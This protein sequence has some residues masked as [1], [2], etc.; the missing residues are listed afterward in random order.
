MNENQTAPK[1]LTKR[2]YISYG[3][4]PIGKNLMYGLVYGEYLPNFFRTKL[5]ISNQF[6][7]VMFFLSKIWDGVNDLLMG[8]IIDRTNSRF[9]KFRPWIFWG[10][11]TNAIV[12][13]MM[14][15]NPGL[16]GAWVYVYVTVLYVMCDMTFTMI[17]VGYWAMIPA[18]TLNPKERE[19]VSILPRVTGAIGG[20]F[21]AFTLNIVSALGKGNDEAGYLR[22]SIIAAVVYI[23][24]SIICAAGTREHVTLKPEVQEKF[25]FKKSAKILFSNKQA[26]VVVVIMTLFNAASCISSGTMFYYFTN[27][28]LKQNVYGIYTTVLGIISAVGL[29]GVPLLSKKMPRNKVYLFSYLLPCIGYTLMIIFN[30][31]A[32]QNFILFAIAGAIPSVSYGAMS[33]MQSVMLSDAVDYGEYETGERHE[34]IIFSMLTFLS[35]MANGI[36]YLIRYSAFALVKFDQDVGTAASE[37]AVSMIKFLL[38]VVP[39]IFLIAAFIIHKKKFALTPDRMEIIRQA[40][41]KTVKSAL[42]PRRKHNGKRKNHY[43]TKIL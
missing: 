32:P 10:A 6:I 7:A 25:S 38:F 31:I 39:Q 1:T 24:T 9:G 4:G 20:L 36:S 16:R 2:D 37:S 33:V 27:V 8:A 18:M 3:L 11:V 26:L 30:L 19:Y 40:F 12:S 17:D 23:A 35:K 29:F 41:L 42:P 43:H 5:G 28:L 21:G 15:Y 14:Y 13:V 34:G 22:F